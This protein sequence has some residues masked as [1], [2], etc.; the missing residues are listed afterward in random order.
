MRRDIHK[1]DNYLIRLGWRAL[2]GGLLFLAFPPEPSASSPRSWMSWV[3]LPAGALMLPS[4][5]LIRAKERKVLVLW[6]ILDSGS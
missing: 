4:G 5:Y 2:L 1:V 6:D 3:A